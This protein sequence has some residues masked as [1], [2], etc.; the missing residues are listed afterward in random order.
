V[1]LQG[2]RTVAATLGMAGPLCRAH[3]SVNSCGRQS[4]RQLN[5]EPC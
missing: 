3:K 4:R 2:S 1:V 5:P